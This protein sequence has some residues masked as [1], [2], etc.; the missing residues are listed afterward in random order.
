M[1]SG[2]ALLAL[3]ALDLE[4]DHLGRQIAKPPELAAYEE[5]HRIADA[6]A[7]ALRA[8]TDEIAQTEAAWTTTEAS[9]AEVDRHAERLRAQLRT[10][11]VVREA[12]ALQHEL[13][14]L[15]QRRSD[16]DEAGLEALDRLDTLGQQREAL[17]QRL[18][19]EQA[20]E[21][22]AQA[23]LEQARVELRA[24]RDDGA[25]R[26]DEVA[27]SVPDS[28]RSRYEQLRQHLGGVG[29]AALDGSRCT[30]CRLDVSRGELESLR[31]AP[32][33]ELVECPNC[34]RLLVR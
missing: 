24:R 31:S 25:R 1:S 5:A 29:A 10:V 22:Q 6:T 20:E 16:L 11:V 3:Q 21:S 4:L 28:V 2:E 9:S 7:Q 34:G 14:T 26:R 19:G 33:D 32:P 23:L 27:A 17:E 18:P 15:A 13:E 12:E 30:G 8:V